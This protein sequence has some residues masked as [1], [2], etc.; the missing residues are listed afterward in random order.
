MHINAGLFSDRSDYFCA[1]NFYPRKRYSARIVGL[2]IIGLIGLAEFVGAQS[3]FINYTTDDGLPSNQV[4]GF[5]QDHNGA[6][7][8]A[9]DR[10]L[11]RFN[12]RHFETYD[13]GSGLPNNIVLKLFPQENGEIWCATA[14]NELFHFHPDTLSFHPYKYNSTLKKI[15]GEQIRGLEVADNGIRFRYIYS[16]GYVQIDNF[17]KVFKHRLKN[18]LF[19]SDIVSSQYVEHNGF[20]FLSPDSGLQ[21]QYAPFH[22]VH[23]DLFTEFDDVVV[24]G[25]KKGVRFCYPDKSVKRIALTEM[26]EASVEDLGICKDG[27][28]VATKQDGIFLLSFEGEKVAHF[29]PETDATHFFVDQHG[30]RWV[31]TLTKG[32]FYWP[33]RHISMLESTRHHT[34]SSI[35]T[36]KDGNLVVGTSDRYFLRFDAKHNLLRKD[37]TIYKAWHRYFPFDDMVIA[38]YYEGNLE[39]KFIFNIS[40]RT[41]TI[42]LYCNMNMVYDVNRN[43]IYRSEH[44]VYDAEFY[45]GGLLCAEKNRLN[46]IRSKKVQE[47]YEFGEHIVDIDVDDAHIYCSTQ[48]EGLHVLDHHFALKY[49]I[50]EASGLSSDFINNMTLDGDTLWICSQGGLDKSFRM[51]DKQVIQGIDQDIG[52]ASQEV[53]CVLIYGDILYAGTKSGLIYFRKSNWGAIHTGRQWSKIRPTNILVGDQV[54]DLADA[55]NY[56]E[57]RIQFEFELI[58]F[59]TLSPP[60]FEYRLHGLETNWNTTSHNEIIYHSLPPNQYAL[61]VRLA[62]S[63]L[64]NHQPLQLE[65]QINTPYYQRW[66]FILAVVAFVVFVVWLFFKYNI[67]RYNRVVVQDILR[68]IN[69]R[70]RTGVN[71]FVVR[72]NGQSVKV[73]SEEIQFVESNGNYINIHLRDQKVVVRERLSSFLKLV[74][75]PSSYLQLRRSLIVRL[76]KIQ[77]VGKDSVQINGQSL[78]VGNTYLPLLKQIDL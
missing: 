76:D 18:R 50:D 1:V 39:T 42:G 38:N 73:I 2:L 31:S 6:I 30:G 4:Y 52:L 74:P 58:K 35:S 32:I 37:T 29:L 44:R 60:L 8:M 68:K 40:D 54:H 51:G 11:I 66:W 28:W 9:T 27:I 15:G 20:H 26:K 33:D 43:H 12:G 17:G 21:S 3:N 13:K 7:W 64:T 77:A 14:S 62:N 61:E 63:D 19:H 16:Y 34:I 41:D 24:R 59:P 70:L 46:Y 36:G 53:N 48:G 69:A 71:S 65:F 56:R 10:G 45:R 55:L 78:K 75:D 22:W 49:V 23:R 57:N 47:S 5:H 72:S 67:L 25:D